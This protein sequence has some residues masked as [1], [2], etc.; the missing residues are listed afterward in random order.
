MAVGGGLDQ[1]GD[2]HRGDHVPEEALTRTQLLELRG[3]GGTWDGARTAREA[4]VR[5]E[6]ALKPVA[7]DG[8]SGYLPAPPPGGP[9]IGHA[10]S[11][12]GLD[13]LA[14]LSSLLPAGWRLEATASAVTVTW[15]R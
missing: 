7:V 3:P 6:E 15:S 2:A 9:E 12:L 14:A 5:H 11:D 8:D 10:T 4:P 1:G 13:R